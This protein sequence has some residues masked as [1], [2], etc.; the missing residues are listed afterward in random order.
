MAKYKKM[1]DDEIL[2][3]IEKG[4]RQAVG[5]HDSKLSRERQDVLEYFH[6]ERPKPQHAGNSRYVSM[7][8]YD[9]VESSKAVLLETF[10]AGNQIVEFVPN[11]PEDTVPARVSSLYTDYAI[12]SQNNGYRVFSDVITDGLLARIGIAKVYWDKREEK[13]EEEFEKLPV[14]QFD[15]LISQP[16]VELEEYELDEDGLV[17]GEICRIKDTSQ[18]CIATIPPEEF[19]INSGAKDID[20]ALFVA[21]RVEKTRSELVAEG[22][23]K[24]IVEKL[25]DDEANF[26]DE[27]RDAR[28]REIEDDSIG[29]ADYLQDQVRKVTVYECYVTLDIEGTGEARLW[30]IIKAGGQVLDKE[31]VNRKPFVTFVPLPIPHSFYGSNFAKKIIPIQN[32]RTVLMRGILDHTVIT[33]NPRYQVVKGSLVNPR[34]LLDNRIGGVVN[35]TR[36]DGIMPLVQASLNPFVFQTIQLL[37]EDKEDTTGISK[38]SQGLNKDAISSQNSGAMVEQLVG[39]SQQRQKI[40]ARNFAN[41]FLVPLYLEVYRLVI[42]NED[43]KKIVELAGEW[44]EITPSRWSERLDVQVALKLGYGEQE[45]EAKKYLGLHQMLTADPGVQPL[46]TVEKR[47]NMLRSFLEKSGVKNVSDYLLSPEQVQPPQPDPMQVMQME[48]QKKQMELQERQV[49]VAEMKASESA[50]MDQMA[51]D[52]DRMKTMIDLMVSQRDIERKEFDSTTRAEIGRAEL[53]ILKSQEPLE[54]K[55]TQIVSPNA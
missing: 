35:V 11:G 15:M 45:N 50:K 26:Y 24:K 34:E 4:V 30:K 25:Y 3:A 47:F 20:D 37:D 52:L 9:A 19:L 49:M 43:K 10:A 13:V 23:D 33:N 32:A 31:E 36:P 7:D 28:L 12:H 14:E 38:L 6:G 29:T 18:V 27:E 54:T 55:Q 16:D 40:V 48:M 2:V 39:L 42:E 53:E 21:H 46:Y 5:Y 8:V 22:Y 41:H 51:H 44:M 17:S 1:T